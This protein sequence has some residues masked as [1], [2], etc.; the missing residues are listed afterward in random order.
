MSKDV[1][2]MTIRLEPDFHTE[3]KGYADALG[4]TLGEWIRRAM[5]EKLER[6][7]AAASGDEE[8]PAPLT[9]E[10]VQKMIHEAIRGHSVTQTNTGDGAKQSVKIGK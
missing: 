4:Q 5:K 9:R 2:Q 1:I 10:E 7:R 6:S 3:C 8:A